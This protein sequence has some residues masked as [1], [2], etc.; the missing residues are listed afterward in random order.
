MNYQN[1]NFCGINKTQY[2]QNITHKKFYSY[3]YEEKINIIS[4]SLVLKEENPNEKYCICRR[5]DDSFNFMIMCE[6]CKEW[7]HGKCMNISK[8]TAEKISTYLCL[9]CSLRKDSINTQYHLDFF[10]YKRIEYPKF[11]KFL[12]EYELITPELP[13]YEILLNI[14]AK[15]EIWTKNYKQL[16]IEI[17]EF[18]KNNMILLTNQIISCKSFSNS[19]ISDFNYLINSNNNGYLSNDNNENSSNLPRNI[20]N[21]VNKINS[22]NCMNVI[23]NQTNVK[24]KNFVVNDTLEKRIIDLYLESEGFPVDNLVAKNLIVILKYHDWFKDSF[25]CVESKKFSE[26]INK[27][28]ISNYQS[29]FI[30]S[31]INIIFEEEKL[32]FEVTNPVSKIFYNLI[33]NK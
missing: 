23:N 31:D 12:E 29:T 2:F 13:E 14:K 8:P 10:N 33:Y 25:K 32:F 19:N 20:T 11:L 7:F 15:M 22:L 1:N 6:N 26:K 28:V 24:I 18:S 9:A 30:L 27:K 4:Q 21:N 17:T 5:G 3:S 16:L